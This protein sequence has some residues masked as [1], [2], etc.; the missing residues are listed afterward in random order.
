MQTHNSVMPL[1]TAY[2]QKGTPCSKAQ[3][4]K[5][6]AWAPIHQSPPLPVVWRSPEQAP[7]PKHAYWV[8][9]VPAECGSHCPHANRG[10]PQLGRPADGYF[11]ASGAGN[12]N[13]EGGREVLYGATMAI[14]WAQLH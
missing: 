10:G 6:T 2:C 8:D 11:V 14:D 3:Q 9:G 12:L 7:H 5:E 4:N 13:K 1:Y